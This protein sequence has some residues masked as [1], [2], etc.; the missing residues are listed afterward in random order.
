MS[1]PDGT[2]EP[3][4]PV[5]P[6]WMTAFLDFAPEG[7]EAGV[8]FWSALTAYDV[9]PRRGDHGEFAT[10]LPPD[11]DAYLRVQ[12]LGEGVD[13]VHLDL[14]VA[15]PRAAARRASGLG[16]AEVADRGYVAMRSPGGLGLCF[17]H[18]GESVRPRPTTWPQGHT[19]ALDQVCIDIPAPAYD[20]ECGFWQEVTGWELR[21]LPDEPE[22]RRLGRPPEQPVQLLLQR[23]EEET[24]PVRA[25]LDWATRAREAEVR[26]HVAL[27]AEVARVHEDWTVLTDPN[28]RAYCVTDRDPEASP[29]G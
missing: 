4:A 27:G 2:G 15:D 7:F 13:G 25:H 12:R 21:D 3:A 26:R 8:D 14:H 24:G 22:F 17:V 18:D 10:L 20:A 5:R 1:T 29:P 16:A 6:T 28:G 11:G 19:S 23:L 9:S